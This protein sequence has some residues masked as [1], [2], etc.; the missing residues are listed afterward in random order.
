M[1]GLAFTGI[2]LLKYGLLLCELFNNTPETDIPHLPYY[3][4]IEMT[5]ALITERR[6]IAYMKKQGQ[7]WDF[8]QEQ[9]PVVN[10]AMSRLSNL[11]GGLPA[12]MFEIT[13]DSDL[14]DT[15][16]DLNFNLVFGSLPDDWLQQFNAGHDWT[17][18]GMD[19]LT[20]TQPT[21]LP[22]HNTLL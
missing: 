14:D 15:T 17:S 5:I 1:T 11:V 18:L 10:M 9:D 2:N 21:T 4:T 13:K 22:T 16:P 7:S 3:L 20:N 19:W 8:F 12:H 6:S